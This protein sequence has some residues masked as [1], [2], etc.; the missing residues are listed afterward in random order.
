MEFCARSLHF[1]TAILT[2]HIGLSGYD[3]LM[4][5]ITCMNMNHAGNPGMDLLRLQ[6]KGH[7]QSVHSTRV[8]HC[9]DAYA[10][11][12]VLANKYA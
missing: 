9:F 11:K 5:R 4:Q 6:T 2:H 8:E 7:I 12:L 10:V 3:D 1:G